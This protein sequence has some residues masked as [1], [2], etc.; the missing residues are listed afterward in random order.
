MT[1]PREHSIA[2]PAAFAAA[3]TAFAAATV[4]A[5]PTAT[6]EPLPR[7]AHIDRAL[8][9]VRALGPAGRDAL[10]RA[11]YEAARAQCR[12]DGGAPSASCLIAAAR[13]ACAPDPDRAR[14]EAAADVVAANLRAANAWVDEPTRIRLVRGSTD[15]RAA[16][17]IELRR[18]YAA[19]ATE[20]VVGPEAA[21]GVGDGAAIDRLC[22]QRDRA[23]HAC[24]PG[25]A[26]CVPSIP[27][28][29]CAAALIWF[30]GGSP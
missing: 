14:C 9:A 29:R 25:D 1:A 4:I 23:V 19:L 8:A 22:A 6:A 18:R 26:A 11:L 12:G 21:S 24:E 10:D 27:W 3:M 15:Y 28:S 20:L 13:A 5:A 16:L 17:A 30:V 7:V 2:A